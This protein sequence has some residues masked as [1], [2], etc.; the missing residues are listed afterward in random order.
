MG[1]SSSVAQHPGSGG[2][3]CGFV[4]VAQCA[5]RTVEGPEIGRSKVN[6]S[7]VIKVVHVLT[8]LVIVVEEIVV[9][10][11]SDIDYIGEIITDADYKLAEVTSGE[12]RGVVG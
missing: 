3:G 8:A 10:E 4:G 11:V 1:L 7:K 5:T 6:Y 9:E 2:S 12:F